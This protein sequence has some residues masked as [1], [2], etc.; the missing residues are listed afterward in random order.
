MARGDPETER[1]ARARATG[2]T[3]VGGNVRALCH[4]PIRARSASSAPRSALPV[5]L[6]DYTQEFPSNSGTSPRSDSYA[7]ERGEG[8][9]QVHAAVGAKIDAYSARLLAESIQDPLLGS[10][11]SI[12]LR[13]GSTYTTRARCGAR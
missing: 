11:A 13:V 3:N 4:P 5:H 7:I 1:T 8:R 6:L 12:L 2:T 10:S 9:G